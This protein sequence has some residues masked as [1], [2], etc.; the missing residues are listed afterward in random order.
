MAQY[1]YYSCQYNNR[2][3][4]SLSWLIVGI[5][6]FIA[7]VA[8][9]LVASS[10]STPNQSAVS[11]KS[12]PSQLTAA[13]TKFDFGTISMAAGQVSKIFKLQ[14]TTDQPVIIEKLYTSCMC[15]T[16]LLLIGENRFGP[17]GMPGHGAVPA[18][19][20]ILAP[21]AAA[22][23][24]VVFDPAAHGPAGIG[25]IQRDVIVESGDGGRLS[26]AFTAQVTP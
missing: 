7:L 22:D 3:G 8:V 20:Q 17:F 6:L 1:S 15:T 25:F 10:P 11:Q 12:K 2:P 24:E 18:V 16:A 14:N 4:S 26:L 13:E 21:G 23:I 9:A 5:G 19:N